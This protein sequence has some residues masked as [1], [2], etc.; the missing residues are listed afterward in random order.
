[1]FNC[2]T[3]LPLTYG[4]NEMFLRRVGSHLHQTAAEAAGVHPEG[5]FKIKDLTA[6]TVVA[7][8]GAGPRWSAALEAQTGTL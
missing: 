1:M 7:L 8:Q 6:L 5:P 4:T 3:V 2:A